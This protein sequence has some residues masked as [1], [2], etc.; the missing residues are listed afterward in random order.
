M[1]VPMNGISPVNNSKKRQPNDQTSAL[2]LYGEPFIT[3]GAISRG[4]PRVVY[5]S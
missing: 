2:W 3:S 1:S 5:A 4:V